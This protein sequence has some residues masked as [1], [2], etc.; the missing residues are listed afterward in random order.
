MFN[1]L[2][3]SGFSLFPVHFVTNNRCS[4]GK[5]DC[6]SPGKHPITRN[7]VKDATKDPSQ[8]KA[9]FSG[10]PTP[11]VGIATGEPSGIIVIDEDEASAYFNWHIANQKATVPTWTV[12]SGKGKHYYFRF[13]ERCKRLKNGVR[14]APGLDIRTTGG[15]VV[16]AG[17]VHVSGKKYEWE[18]GPDGPVPLADLPDWLFELLPKKEEQ[19]QS[20]PVVVKETKAVPTTFYVTDS[21]DEPSLQDRAK[22]FLKKYP[23]AVSGENGH[24]QTYKVCCRLI[25]LF[26]SLPDDDLIEAMREWNSRCVPAWSD[27]E[28]R[29][30]LSEARKKTEPEESEAAQYLTDNADDLS[31]DDDNQ[32]PVLDPD[33][34]HGIAGEMI[35]AIDPETE[36][37]PVAILVSFLTAFGNAVGNRPYFAV[38]SDHHCG[39]LFSC[40]VG[41]TA[42]G[43]GQSWGIVQ[44]LMKKIDSDWILESISHGGLSS[45]EGF[46]ERL[47]DD[48]SDDPL[49][50]QPLK[51]VLFFESE[52]AKPI[53]AMRRENNTLSSVLRSSWDRSQLSIL[54][55]GK[56]KLIASNAFVSV[57]SHVTPS[58][59][60]KLLKDSIESANGFSNRF[61]WCLVR[62][63]KSLPHG[64]NVS[65][66]NQFVDRL[67]D[68]LKTAKTIGQLKRSKE[69]DRLWEAV[70][71]E[72]K[73]AGSGS[74][75]RAIERA[76]P[77]VLR[78]S[79]LYALLDSSNVIHVHHLK[80][81]LAVWRYCSDS[82]RLIFSQANDEKADP[83]ESKIFSILADGPKTKT[84]IRNRISSS[85]SVRK[86]FPNKIDELVET[87]RIAFDGQRYSLSTVQLSVS[88][89]DL[90]KIQTDKWTKWTNGQV[91]TAKNLSTQPVNGQVDKVD[92]GHGG[93]TGQPTMDIGQLLDWKNAN[94]VKF[95][96]DDE[97]AIWVTPQHEHLITPAIAEAIHANQDVLRSFVPASPVQEPEPKPA[98]RIFD[99]SKTE[100]VPMTD[101]EFLRVLEGVDIDD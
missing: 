49:F 54:T 89:D 34:L 95:R 26:G 61:L 101:D 12:R 67:R 90:N 39:N 56:S 29:H 88:N 32:W 4:C 43:K 94:G 75:G 73:K 7:G 74:F 45:G 36:A 85:K 33:A 15:C 40:I 87:K 84:E 96:M 31:S 80:A 92:S 20:S 21:S 98:F 81:A 99:Y 58:E 28:L 86:E 62:S 10:N 52:F 11:N 19:K 83:L 30:K 69:A 68:V 65:V 47:S 22:A 53:S 37:D 82:A 70:Y 66:L 18:N 63:E 2:V 9:W 44:S 97:E 55:R 72:L 78:L 5:S 41:D 57:L 51:N 76:R 42:S 13:D 3:S 93:Q 46:V 50:K 27:S 6:G 100:S 71:S 25:E 17:S 24:G 8:I 60:E 59:L 91:D 64:G 77:Q 1:V 38:G 79:L 14:F 35:K 23:E 48:E 16:G